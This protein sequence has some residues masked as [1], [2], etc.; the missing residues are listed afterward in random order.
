MLISLKAHDEALLERSF[1]QLKTFYD[2]TRWV[3]PVDQCCCLQ[4]A[5]EQ[6]D[7]EACCITLASARQGYA[8]CTCMHIHI[9]AVPCMQHP[10]PRCTLEAKA[11]VSGQAV[12]GHRAFLEFQL[13]LG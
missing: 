3:R 2:D 1:A 4:V 5:H 8:Q 11:A 12:A 7:S 13:K 6:L 10:S 9:V